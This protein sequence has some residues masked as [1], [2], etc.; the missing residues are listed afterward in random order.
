MGLVATL[1]WISGHAKENEPH[2]EK[3]AIIAYANSKRRGE[4]ALQHSLA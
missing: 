2:H 4:P 3:R 1:P